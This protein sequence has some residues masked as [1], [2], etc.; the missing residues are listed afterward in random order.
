MITFN[1]CTINFLRNQKLY[2]LQTLKIF[3]D[4]TFYLKFIAVCKN[5]N[6]NFSKKNWDKSMKSIQKISMLHFSQ[7]PEIRNFEKKVL[8]VYKII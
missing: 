8:K 1:I 2:K 7:F 6:T 5:I 3:L 4:K